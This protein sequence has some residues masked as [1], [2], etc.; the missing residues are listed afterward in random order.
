MN[1]VEYDISDECSKIINKSFHAMY[2]EHPHECNM[3]IYAGLTLIFAFGA[4]KEMKA[5]P[6]NM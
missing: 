6:R 5:I 4:Y 1:K 2:E 3:L